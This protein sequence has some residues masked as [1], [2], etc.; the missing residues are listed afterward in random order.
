M[1]EEFAIAVVNCYAFV[2]FLLANIV[3]GF[4][5]VDSLCW[6]WSLIMRLSE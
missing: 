3:V 2:V 5:V 1:G 4:K 6:T